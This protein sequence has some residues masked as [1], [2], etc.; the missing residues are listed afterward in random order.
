MTGEY[1]DLWAAMLSLATNDIRLHAR[2]HEI[3][4][5]RP[6]E[7]KGADAASAAEWIMSDSLRLG[8]FLWVCDVLGLNPVRARSKVLER[9]EKAE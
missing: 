9:K 3:D 7:I 6:E 1:R 2:R 8:G 5:S 4:L